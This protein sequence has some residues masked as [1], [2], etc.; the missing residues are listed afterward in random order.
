MHRVREE[1]ENEGYDRAHGFRSI[2]VENESEPAPGI[3]GRTTENECPDCCCMAL[4]D[5]YH[6]CTQLYTTCTQEQRDAKGDSHTP[7]NQRPDVEIL[8]WIPWDFEART[9]NLD[10]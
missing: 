10:N 4:A 1:P 2:S 9:Q 5:A 6:R 8:S 3:V 7:N